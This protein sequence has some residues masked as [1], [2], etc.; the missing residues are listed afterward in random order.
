MNAAGSYP[1]S[2]QVFS[3]GYANSNLIFTYSLVISD[4]SAIEG[5]NI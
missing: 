4:I 5:D 3:K 2:V 1:V